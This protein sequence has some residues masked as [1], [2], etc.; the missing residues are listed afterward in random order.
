MAGFVN[1]NPEYFSRL[2]KE[3]TGQTFNSYLNE[4]RLNKAAELVANSNK[5]LSDIASDVGFSSLSYFSKKFKRHFGAN[6]FS[7]KQGDRLSDGP[8]DA[9]LP[10]S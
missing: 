10:P 9:A 1:L 5:K 3:E 2:F 7:Y 8:D 6:P 4:Y